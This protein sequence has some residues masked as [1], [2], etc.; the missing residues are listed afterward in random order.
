M[1]P[2]KNRRFKPQKPPTSS[3]PEIETEIDPAS[4][5]GAPKTGAP[6]TGAPEAGASRPLQPLVAAIA[7]AARWVGLPVRR[8]QAIALGLAG[9]L[10]ALAIGLPAW[11]QS[12]PVELSLL[13][14][15]PEASD[16]EPLI[17]KFEAENPDI[18][19]NLVEGPSATNLIED[20]HTSAFILGDSPYDLIY[21][22]IAWVPKFA[23]A[24]WLV[25]LSDRISQEE[26]D[27]FLPGDVAGGRY[28][29]GLYRLPFRTDMGM[30]YYR[31]DLLA[32]AG[33]DPPQTF[34][35]LMETSKALQAETQADWGYLWQGKQYEGL[36]AMFVEILEGYG[37][38]W[39]DP[40]TNEVGLDRPEAI[41]A[42]QFLTDTIAEGVSPPG[43]TTYTEP[44]TLRFFRNGNSIFLRN[45]PYV[46]AEVN[47]DDSPIKGK[48]A[49]KPMVHKPGLEGG[50]CQGGWG[51]G[52]A[53]SSQH[54]DEAWRAIEFFSSPEVQ[55]QFV[56]DTSYISARKALAED[57]DVIAAYPPYPKL[58]EIL[59]NNAVLRP[60]IP[61]YAQASDILQR[62]LTAAVTGSMTPEAAMQKAA[63]ETRTLLGE[64]A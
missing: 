11:T 53:K 9:L 52:I 50:A 20:L 14:H 62:Y 18:R 43:T 2:F 37:A 55:K 42:V 45:W 33:Y 13:M 3:A 57:P 28:Q 10:L 17:D 19:I 60:P 31:E 27:A 48:V 58:V 32:E 29:G 1:N 6:E 4:Q 34:A 21:L 12:Q 25:D 63:R 38:F 44:E 22:D 35:E 49:I 30:L 46:W 41:A 61:Q 26:L 5:T 16:W 64:S 23:A 51:L 56:L 40:D 59:A 39:V 7:R 47:K 24:G 8:L 36:S 15:V 54:P